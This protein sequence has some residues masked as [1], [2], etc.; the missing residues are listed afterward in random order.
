MVLGHE[1]TCCADPRP[2]HGVRARGAADHVRRACRGSGRRLKAALE[3]AHRGRAGRAAAGRRA[4]GARRGPAPR[5]RRAGGRGGGRCARRGAC[6]APTSW[7]SRPSASDSASTRSTASWPGAAPTPVDVLEFFA[8][9]RHRHLRAVGHVRADAAWPR[10]IHRSASRSGPWA[11]R[12]PGVELRLAD[13][14]EVLVRG[15][16]RHAGLP[17]PARA[18]RRRRSTPTAGCTPATSATLDED[19][20]LT[21]VDRKKELIIN[22]AGK[23]MSP[24]NI[25]GA[26][27]TASPLIGQACVIG[28]RRPYNVALIVLDPDGMRRV[29]REHGVGDEAL[30]AL[31]EAEAVV[32]R[33]RE[34]VRRANDRLSRV[35]QI[36][37]FRDPRGRL[38]AGR[39][40][41]DADDEAQAPADRREVRRGDRGALHRG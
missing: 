33:S 23:N 38:G 26:L 4:V 2:G 40:R 1:V 11:R 13:D 34:G 41:A 20:Y 9:H 8:A 35:E 19:G 39:R 28:D 36:K 7:C 18:G 30:G 15:D 16:D 14:G 3:A 27:K 10:S 6:A 37:R 5:A 24:A 22:A 31:A 29:R 21:I 12:S 17:Q 32:E 25:E